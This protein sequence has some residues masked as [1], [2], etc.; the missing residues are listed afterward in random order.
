MA[1]RLVRPLSKAPKPESLG[2]V[3][4]IMST[5]PDAYGGRNLK[6]LVLDILG[7]QYWK[8]CADSILLLP[9]RQ[10]I[11]PLISLMLHNDPIIR[12]RAVIAIGE[13]VNKLV[14]TDM[15]GARIVMRRFM[16]S[17]NDESGG[18]G[19]GAPEA[20]CVCVARNHKIADEF[21]HMVVSYLNPDGNYLEYE[22]LQRG[23]LWGIVHV[24][25]KSPDVVN[26]AKPFLI[27]YLDSGDAHVRGLAI[28]AL[29][30]LGV[31]ES[32]ERLRDLV[33]D[34]SCFSTYVNDE[35]KT[36]TVGEK[37]SEASKALQ[38]N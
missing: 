36:F 24:A 32:A 38:K 17:L 34:G 16:W 12:W 10:V 9:E 31:K 35:I 4:R 29:N 2:R 37:A 14:S 20:M 25:Q 18:I 22:P 30:L 33:S 3:C 23:L 21:G 11:N 19:W 13:V 26:G 28:M 27:S 5:K 7:L 6:R 8:D 15:E 1:V